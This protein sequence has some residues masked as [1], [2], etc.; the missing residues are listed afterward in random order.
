LTGRR[1]SIQVAP[2]EL[3]YETGYRRSGPTTGRVES[4]V[5]GVLK[6]ERMVR[7]DGRDFGL[8]IF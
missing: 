6:V 4:E 7:D 2:E 8:V 5:D 3:I 1:E